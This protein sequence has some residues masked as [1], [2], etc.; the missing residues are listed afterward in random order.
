MKLGRV[1]KYRNCGLTLIEVMIA[2]LV[3]VVIVIGALSYMY[4]CALNAR[5][6]DVRITATRVGQLLLETWKV[7]GTIVGGVWDVTAFNPT[8][9]F[10]PELANN[11]QSTAAD[12]GGTG[13]EL[14]DYR[15]RIDGVHYFVTLL[16]NSSRP[17]MLSARVAWNRN[18]TS[19]TLES[20]FR[21]VDLTSHAIY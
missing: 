17:Q 12:L 6:A 3:A 20:D 11:F 18:L 16:Y 5:A 10:G 4:A 8:T 14:G 21:Y 1:W 13:V 9:A 7:T 19:T 15:I 2:V